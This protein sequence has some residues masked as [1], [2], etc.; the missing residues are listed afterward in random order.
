MADHEG[1][2]GMKRRRAA[3]TRDISTE[4]KTPTTTTGHRHRRR[5]HRSVTILYRT[6][7]A[8]AALAAQPPANAQ[9]RRWA[10]ERTARRRSQYYANDRR[11]RNNTTPTRHTHR[12][13][14]RARQQ[15]TARN[16]TY[17]C[18]C[19]HD[20]CTFSDFSIPVTCAWV[21]RCRLRS[22]PQHIVVEVFSL[23]P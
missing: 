18:N 22:A 21:Y 6:A 15:Y 12:G 8:R 17:H 5:R 14:K 10:G 16:W 13:R 11:T 3:R 2:A 20:R 23:A 7:H 4:R 1:S 19:S 9:K